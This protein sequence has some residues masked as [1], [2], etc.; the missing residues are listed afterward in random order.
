MS[1]VT[2]GS[3]WPLALLAVLP[4]VWLLAWHNRVG[5]GRLRMIGATVLRSLALIAIVVA[6]MRPTLQIKSAD[7]SV[8]YGVDISAS[9]SS[10]FLDRALNW[11]GQVNAK[12]KPAQSR[13]VVFADRAKLLDSVAEVRSLTVATG[14]GPRSRQD[15]IHQSATNLETGLLATL[16]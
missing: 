15:L 11:I 6:L 5:A 7:L 13:L 3:Y 1:G 4:V 10:H 9:V 16:P 2:V 8:A 12:H 14:D